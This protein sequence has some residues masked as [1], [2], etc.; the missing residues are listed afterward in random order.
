M[1]RAPALDSLSLTL[2]DKLDVSTASGG[3]DQWLWLR[4]TSYTDGTTGFAFY[5]ANFLSNVVFAAT[6]YYDFVEY[7]SVKC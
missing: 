2:R 7:V 6:S 1:P 3:P 4:P 5:G